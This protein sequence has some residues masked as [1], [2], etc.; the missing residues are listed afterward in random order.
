MARRMLAASAETDGSRRELATPAPLHHLVTRPQ[1][2]SRQ[3]ASPL[4]PSAAS[5]T[6]IRGRSAPD[7]PRTQAVTQRYHAAW[8]ARRIADSAALGESAEVLRYHYP[9]H[10]ALCAPAVDTGYL[11]RAVPTPCRKAPDPG[12]SSA[13]S[14][15]AHPLEPR[16]VAVGPRHGELTAVRNKRR[17]RELQR[18]GLVCG[19]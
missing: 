18:P 10:R 1:S 19:P 7:R 15:S 8:F 5:P 6:P 3:T 11:R 16:R 2:P 4:D 17:S 13:A 9:V 12:K 14:A